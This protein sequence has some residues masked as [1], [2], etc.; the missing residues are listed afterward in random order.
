MSD[1]TETSGPPA[2]SRGGF[3]HPGDTTTAYRALFCTDAAGTARTAFSQWRALAADGEPTQEELL[4]R[5]QWQLR[6]LDVLTEAVRASR[7][8][9]IKDWKANGTWTQI[10]AAAKVPERTVRDWAKAAPV[11]AG[12]PTA[13]G[14]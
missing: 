9:L 12:G 13:D 4:A 10:A 3:A 6:A 11:S 5:H 1:V 2:A 8:Q 14:I 7:G